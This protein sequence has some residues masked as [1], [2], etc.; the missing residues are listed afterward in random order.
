MTFQNGGYDSSILI[1]DSNEADRHTVN[2]LL[3]SE[4]YSPVW[5]VSGKDVLS[6]VADKKIDLI[7]MDIMMPGTDWPEIVKQLKD[8]ERTSC[9]P[10]ILVTA[11]ENRAMKIKVLQTGAEEVLSRPLDFDELIIRIRNLLRSKE[12]GDFLN[13]YNESLKTEIKVRSNRLEEAYRETLITLVRASEF[14]DE[15]TGLHINR[16]GRYSCTLAELL[17]MDEEFIRTILLSSLMHDVGKIGIPDSIL[18]KHDPLNAQEMK[19]MHSHCILGA[20]ILRDGKSRYLV[21][22]AEIALSHHER[23]DGSGYPYGLA[24]NDIPLSAR[25]TQIADVYDALRC[26]RPY[27]PALDHTTTMRI[28]TEGDGRTMPRHFDPDVLAVFRENADV[29]DSI[30]TSSNEVT[31]KKEHQE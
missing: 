18:L 3:V 16:I 26:R 6:I 9:I 15:D 4:G 2:A 21:M 13:Y 31:E 14:R 12:Y 20:E 25:I 17:G 19:I 29:F 5:A 27:K 23:W 28:L 24:G 22:G 30:F 1:A 11:G 7:L 8:N 10:V